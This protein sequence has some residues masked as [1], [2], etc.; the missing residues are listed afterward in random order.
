MEP[1]SKGQPPKPPRLGRWSRFSPTRLIKTLRLAYGQ[2][3]LI[4]LDG[5]RSGPSSPLKTVPPECGRWCPAHPG[6]RVEQEVG[7]RRRGTKRASPAQTQPR[8]SDAIIKSLAV[9]D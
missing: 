6:R 7:C 9:D 1:I 3:L 4:I 2:L 5:A 8:S